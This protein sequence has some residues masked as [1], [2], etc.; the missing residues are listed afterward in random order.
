M[1]IA[2]MGHKIMYQTDGH[3]TMSLCHIYHRRARNYRGAELLSGCPF[4][5]LPLVAAP[6]IYFT[7]NRKMM[8]VTDEFGE[9]EDSE[10]TSDT[11]VT[12]TTPL[13]ANGRRVG[14]H[15][16]KW[17]TWTSVC[18]A[19]NQFFELLSSYCLFDGW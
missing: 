12:E 4:V 15:N 2:P 7:A 16:S 6:L 8:T 3:R 13:N 14:F 11:T 5:I 9:P 18:L 1:V 17:L 19:D 10:N